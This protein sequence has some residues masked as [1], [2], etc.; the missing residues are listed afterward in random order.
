[1]QVLKHLGFGLMH[2]FI[3]LFSIAAVELIG[4]FWLAIPFGEAMKAAGY[5]GLLILIIATALMIAPIALAWK[6]LLRYID[7]L[8]PQLKRRERLIFCKACRTGTHSKA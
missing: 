2:G 7:W 5:D 6:P 1:M 8:E 4:I 3:L